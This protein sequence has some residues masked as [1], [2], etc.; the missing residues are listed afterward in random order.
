MLATTLSNSSF[1]RT[2]LMF[3]LWC[4]LSHSRSTP[5]YRDCGM[6]WLTGKITWFVYRTE[7]IISLMLRNKQPQVQCVWLCAY[8]LFVFW[9]CGILEHEAS[10]TL[11]RHLSLVFLEMSCA[12]MFTVYHLLCPPESGNIS[13]QCQNTWAT[14]IGHHIGWSTLNTSC[15]TLFFSLF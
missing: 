14:M 6:L 10:F 11:W 15:D 13:I 2:L 9:Y 8:S 1:W 3:L 12:W 7:E 4:T 5:S